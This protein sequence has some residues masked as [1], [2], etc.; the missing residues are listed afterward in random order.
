MGA[1]VLRPQE[2]STFPQVFHRVVEKQ[3]IFILILKQYTKIQHISSSCITNTM[4]RMNI[5]H[6]ILLEGLHV[7]M[8]MH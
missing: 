1:D 5:S 3:S 2:L 4:K 8:G 6:Q 7:P